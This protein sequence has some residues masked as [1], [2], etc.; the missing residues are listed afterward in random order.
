MQC[1]RGEV[2]RRATC[3]I[4]YRLSEE[5][6]LC[7]REGQLEPQATHRYGIEAK[8]TAVMEGALTLPEAYRFGGE[9]YGALCAEKRFCPFLISR[10]VYN[11]I[12]PDCA[13]TQEPK[14]DANKT[15]RES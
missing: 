1:T 14:E 3:A 13:P 9:A 4:A 6:K 12:A 15:G 2:E 8:L 5:N 10:G 11:K 7:D